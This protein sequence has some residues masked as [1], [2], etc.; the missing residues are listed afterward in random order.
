MI[1]YPR[2]ARALA[3][4]H[5]ARACPSTASPRPPS[6]PSSGTP[7]RWSTR[8]TGRGGRER[9]AWTQP[10]ARPGPRRW[11]PRFRST[12]VRLRRVRQGR[13][14]AWGA[15]KCGYSPLTGRRDATA[16]RQ[17]VVATLLP[18]VDGPF[19]ARVHLCRVFAELS[20]E[21]GEFRPPPGVLCVAAG[22]RA[23]HRRASR[24]PAPC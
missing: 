1:Q 8:R 14:G 3:S 20:V 21:G 19:N 24:H 23:A 6:R 22:G 11:L 2:S 5:G 10:R 16:V 7:E 13:A 12:R 4:T 18:S 15:G 17:R 9:W